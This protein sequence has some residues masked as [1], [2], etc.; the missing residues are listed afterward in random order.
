MLAAGLKAHAKGQVYGKSPQDVKEL[1]EA[2]LTSK[3]GQCDHMAAAVVAKI[4]HH[5]RQ[6]G[7][8]IPK[9]R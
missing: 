3:S 6:G 1:G 2:L 9:W 8:G 5:L 7:A 4:V